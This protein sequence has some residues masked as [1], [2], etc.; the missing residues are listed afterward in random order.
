[1]ITC[2]IRRS[3]SVVNRPEDRATQ[4]QLTKHGNGETSMTAWEDHLPPRMKARLAA[5]GESRP[6]ERDLVRQ[7]EEARCLLAEFYKDDLDPMGLSG[8]L[9]SGTSFMIREAQ[10]SLIQSLSLSYSSHSFERRKI[11]TLELERLKK[12]G[13]VRVI[14]EGLNK[15]AEIRR[16]CRETLERTL[17][18]VTEEEVRNRE[19]M[20]TP[21][22]WI[23]QRVTLSSDTDLA[24][25]LAESQLQA[26]RKYGEEFASR[27]R[28]LTS[29]IDPGN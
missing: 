12:D 8:K 7:K 20:I 28:Q 27:V 23:T 2:I 9:K 13:R 16:A 10:L 25:R 3:S 19:P 21:G 4:H 29:L 18:E 5:I 1:M 17:R 14:E 11:A 15:I 26:E 6:E 24:E 22:K